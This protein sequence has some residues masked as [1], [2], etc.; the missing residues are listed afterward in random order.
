VDKVIG[1]I[2][3][4]KTNPREL[5]PQWM[6]SYEHLVTHSW[7]AWNWNIFVWG[8]GNL[9]HMLSTI[10][11]GVRLVVGYD[12]VDMEVLGTDPLENRGLV[13]ELRPNDATVRNDALGS[14]QV[15]Y[16]E[17]GG[18]PFVSTS[19]EAVVNGIGPVT[20]DPGLLVSYLIYQCTVGR[21]TL[22]K[23][24]KKQYANTTLKIGLNGSFVET[25]QDPLEIKPF[26]GSDPIAQMHDLS[27]RTVRKYTAPRE[28]MFLPL[29]SGQDSCV[30]LGS[31][32]RPNR[33]KARSHPS[34]W[35]AERSW[36]TMIPK[37]RAAICGVKDWGMLDF[38]HDYSKWT[39][40]AIRYYGTLISAV[41]VYLFGAAQMI[42]SEQLHLPVISGV[43]GDV[44]AG[45]GF[46]WLE[47]NL[48]RCHDSYE[49]Y[50]IGCYCHDKEWVPALLDKVLTYDWRVAFEQVKEDGRRIWDQTEGPDDIIRGTLVRLRN[51]CSQYVVYTWGALDLWNSMVPV[52]CDRDYVS[53]ML[54]FPKNV[55]RNRIG[56]QQMLRT[57]H[58]N[59]WFNPG[60]DPKSW[61]EDN[62]LNIETINHGLLRSLWPLLA[63]G[64]RPASCFFNPNE[65]SKLI[66]KALRPDE[67]TWFKLNSLQ[68]LAWAI[69]EGWTNS[70]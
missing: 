30:I 66:E 65:I 59:I 23:E 6:Q 24:I 48:P 37:A 9:D 13:V 14:M 70:A 42:G 31:T 49:Q 17:K 16:G 33:I 45:I 61:C 3:T 19:E 20:L 26:R 58:G 40:P 41:Q 18:C 25:L 10:P 44:V 38:D 46:P 64:F 28:T 32:E 35:P 47:D 29:S 21:L 57:Y 67:H 39:E 27:V 15:V 8:H 22:W 60:L 43:I 62:T 53:T 7:Q 69:G 11:E 12:E 51:R 52:Y 5:A 63:T 2:L 34:S 36:E 4:T 68:S 55:L 1:F 50:K 56:Q 54:G